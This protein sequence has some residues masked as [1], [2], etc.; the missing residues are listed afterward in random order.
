[1]NLAILQYMVDNKNS[2][3][4]VCETIAFGTLQV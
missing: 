4:V 3:Q 1:M 2:I